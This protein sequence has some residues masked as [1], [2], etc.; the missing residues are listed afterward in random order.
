[1]RAAAT[2]V[3]T[4]R[5][6]IES[7]LERRSR[8]RPDDGCVLNLEPLSSWLLGFPGSPQQLQG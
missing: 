7:S 5:V 6:A 4:R 3:E 2:Y 1:M 8:R